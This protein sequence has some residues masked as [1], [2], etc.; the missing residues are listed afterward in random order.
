LGCGSEPSPF[1]LS[2]MHRKKRRRHHYRK[3]QFSIAQI[4]AWADDFHQRVGSWPLPRSGRIVGSLGETW[5]VVD[6][7]L[8]KGY[9]GLPGGSS[10]ARLLVAHRG[11]RNPAALPDLT[12]PRILAWAD[13]YHARTGRWPQP[14]SGRIPGSGGESWNG[15]EHALRKGSRGLSESTLA[16][17]LAEHRGKRNLAALPHL[18]VPAILAWADDHRRRTGRWPTEDAGQVVS[19]GG[20]T[21]TGISL[22]LARGTRGLRGGSSLARLLAEH[23]GKRNPAGLPDLTI[24]QILAWADSHHR[25]TGEWPTRASGPVAGAPAETWHRLDDALRHGRRK[26]PGDSSL[27]WLLA[28]RRGL[29]NPADLPP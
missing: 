3:P 20:E 11:K 15:V 8:D 18:T 7:A 27:A 19:S 14:L 22:A 1:I 4:L 13:A 21:W 10:L 2:I 9:R 16:R 26:L 25:R 23:R 5:R 12:V 17:L 24:A 6:K 29:R 28:R